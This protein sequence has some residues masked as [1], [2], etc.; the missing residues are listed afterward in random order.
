[1]GR[2]K[3]TPFPEPVSNRLDN[4]THLLKTPSER[5]HDG[6]SLGRTVNSLLSA[7][8]L[9]PALPTK[10][11]HSLKATATTARLLTAQQRN[12]AHEN[13]LDKNYP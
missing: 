2:G 6:M 4:W 10:Q 9:P 3:A 7:A 8:D 13:E 5:E 11:G 12:K 1:M